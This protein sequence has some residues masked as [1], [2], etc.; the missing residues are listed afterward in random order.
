M[1]YIVS[2][3][4]GDFAV[5]WCVVYGG[6]ERIDGLEQ[7]GDLVDPKQDRPVVKILD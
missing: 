4:L 5:L 1:C 3:P 7:M 2:S 6:K